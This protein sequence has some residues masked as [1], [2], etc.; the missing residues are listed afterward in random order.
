MRKSGFY[1]TNQKLN[2]DPS[3]ERVSKPGWG[4]RQNLKKNSSPKKQTLIMVEGGSRL[5]LQS[6]NLSSIAV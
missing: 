6:N 3:S 5:K 2:K 4:Q 1:R